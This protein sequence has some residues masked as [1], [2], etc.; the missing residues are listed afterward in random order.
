M[1]RQYI[2]YR[3]LKSRSAASLVYRTT[4]KQRIN[5]KEARKSNTRISEGLMQVAAWY[6]GLK[7]TSVRK[8]S[9]LTETANTAV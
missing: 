7:A 8:T 1:T 5:E 9:G 2:A 3:I 4:L 6:R